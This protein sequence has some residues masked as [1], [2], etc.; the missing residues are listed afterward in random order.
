MLTNSEGANPDSACAP[1][2]VRPHH[3]SPAGCACSAPL[4]WITFLDSLLTTDLCETRSLL[5]SSLTIVLVMTAILH[6]GIRWHVV[7]KVYVRS[8]SGRGPVQRHPSRARARAR[9][10]V[11]GRTPVAV[12]LISAKSPA[13]E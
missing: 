12:Q 11:C 1:G 3:P 10:C 8:A 2:H 7:G 4:H 13:S 6:H 5:P 9:V